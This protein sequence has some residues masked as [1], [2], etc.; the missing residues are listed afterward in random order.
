[1]SLLKM[2]FVQRSQ[3]GR[4][5]KTQAYRRCLYTVICRYPYTGPPTYT[6]TFLRIYCVSSHKYQL[7]SSDYAYRH[8]PAHKDRICGRREAAGQFIDVGC[9]TTRLHFMAACS[10]CL[11][12]CGI[13]RGGTPRKRE[14]TG[15]LV[16][17][18][19]NRGGTQCGVY[20]RD[21]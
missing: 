17:F 3:K 11:R 16:T 15:G 12:V 14:C 1:M 20:S 9:Y 7:E 8:A 13:A 6:I 2:W 4:G 19:R 5:K 10:A 18:A 21:V